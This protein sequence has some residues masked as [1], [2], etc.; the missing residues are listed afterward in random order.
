MFYYMICCQSLCMDYSLSPQLAARHRLVWFA[1]W[2][3]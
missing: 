1:G 3:N 2:M